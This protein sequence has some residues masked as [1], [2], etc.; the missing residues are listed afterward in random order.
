L[1]KVIRLTLRP[2]QSRRN[3]TRYRIENWVHCN[4]FGC[5]DKQKNIALFGNRVSVLW[6]RHSNV[7]N[8]ATKSVCISHL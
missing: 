1:K 2:H 4:S 5:G 6:F 8:W 3:T 7:T